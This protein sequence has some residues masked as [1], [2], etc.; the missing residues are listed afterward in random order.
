M[1]DIGA[2]A[3]NQYVASKISVWWD[4]E[5]CQVPERWRGCDPHSIANNISSA[6]VNLNYCGPLSISAYADTNRIPP[7]VQHALSSTGISLNHVPAGVKDASDKKILV[8][9]LFWAVD[10]PAPGNIMLISGDRDFSNALHQ[11]RMRR[12]NILLAQPDQNSTSSAPDLL[13][14]AKTV[15]LWSSLLSG[16]PP[17]N[18]QRVFANTYAPKPA[19]PLRLKHI[20]V[21]FCSTNPDNYF[22]NGIHMPTSDSKSK[23]RRSPPN[24]TNNRRSPPAAGA[25]GEVNYGNSQP[26]ANTLGNPEFL[27]RD[28]SYN[29]SSLPPLLKTPNN[30]ANQKPSFDPN[31]APNHSYYPQTPWGYPSNVPEI[32]NFDNSGYSNNNHYHN[33][34]EFSKDP[35]KN[36]LKPLTLSDARN[37]KV[38]NNQKN[39]RNQTN[40]A[41]GYV[42]FPKPSQYVQGFIEVVLLALNTL[43]NE[44]IMP[45]EE[46]ISDCIR[47]GNFKNQNTDIKKALEFAVEQQLVVKQKVGFTKLYIGKNEKL[48]KC[49]NPLSGNPNQYPKTTW[50]RIQ[51]F[52]SSSTGRSAILA[53]HCRYEAGTIVKNICLKE[54]T[55]GNILQILNMVISS[56]KWIVHDQSGWQPL[57]ITLNEAEIVN[58]EAMTNAQDNPILTVVEENSI[59]FKSIS[60]AQDNPILT[61]VEEKPLDVNG[62]TKG[63]DNPMLTVYEEKPI[64]IL[65]VKRSELDQRLDYWHKETTEGSESRLNKPRSCCLVI[66]ETVPGIDNSLPTETGS[67]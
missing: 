1:G 65:K 51:K 41:S 45:T 38:M 60:K 24:G 16:G 50:D 46:N 43:K 19:D 56:K 15:W 9:M 12:Y 59:D 3:E 67:S 58:L 36:I 39:N 47:Y 42:G 5:N 66:T 40:T 14:A 64:D 48:W 10:N 26:N 34:S 57:N 53:S 18:N 23:S 35:P 37:G 13:A 62:I 63:Q 8:D 49:V 29:P 32:Q 33:R 20:P 6:L 55:L 27:W 28:V 54:Y 31:N 2:I 17:V 25:R 22:P 44:K 21:D 7:S 11:L 30:I 61:V 4:I 52:M